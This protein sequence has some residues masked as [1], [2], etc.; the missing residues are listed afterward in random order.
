MHIAANIL[1]LRNI[2]ENNDM[3]LLDQMEEVLVEFLDIEKSQIS[4]EIA[5]IF[6]INSSFVRRNK[7]PRDVHIIFM[8]R[9][10]KEDILKRSRENL[11][12]IQG[13]EIEILK[14]ILWK[15]WEI[16]KQYFFFT[17][18]LN[19]KGINFR[20]LTTEGI[21]LN[22]QSKRFRL[23]SLDKTK[24]FYEKYIATGEEQSPSTETK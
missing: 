3:D 24:D 21:I 20:W 5:K 18:K 19:E 6:R 11:L 1:R 7:T 13:K 23:D 22:W 8:R 16:R 12:R 4:R 10:I 9:K 2:P 17:K 14:Q 15:I